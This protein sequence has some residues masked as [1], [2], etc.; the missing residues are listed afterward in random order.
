MAREKEY[1]RERLAYIRENYGDNLNLAQA[2]KYLGKDRRTVERYIRKRML[3]AT[4][5]ST[6]VNKQYLI[7]A[8]A[9]ANL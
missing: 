5:V 8:C 7:S 3:P 1:Y 6:G 9:L 2:A 4:D